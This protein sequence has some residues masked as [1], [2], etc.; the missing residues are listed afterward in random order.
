MEFIELKLPAELCRN[1]E[2]QVLSEIDLSLEKLVVALLEELSN[3]AA[4]L[5]SAE[6]A[7]LEQRLRDLGYL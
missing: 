6:D 1:V 2:A 3:R 5:D 4:V 7:L